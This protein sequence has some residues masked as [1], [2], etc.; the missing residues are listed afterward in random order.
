M[1]RSHDG[2]CNQFAKGKSKKTFTVFQDAWRPIT[3]MSLH[4][5]NIAFGFM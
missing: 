3:M 2:L 1:Q 5:Y 4:N